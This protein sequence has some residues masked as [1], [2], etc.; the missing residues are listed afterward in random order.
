MH[1]NV[2]NQQP[3]PQSGATSAAKMTSYMAPTTG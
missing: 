2:T 1:V 3:M